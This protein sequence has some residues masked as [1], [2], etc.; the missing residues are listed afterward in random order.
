SMPD[1]EVGKLFLN[2]AEETDNVG[3]FRVS[4]TDDIWDAVRHFFAR[5]D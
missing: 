2:L 5:G 3:A 4:G 1:S